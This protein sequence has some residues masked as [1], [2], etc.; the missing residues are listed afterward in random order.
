MPDAEHPSDAYDILCSTLNNER[1]RKRIIGALYGYLKSRIRAGKLSAPPDLRQLA[2]VLLGDVAVVALERAATFDTTKDPLAWLLGIALNTVRGYNRDEAR[3][4]KRKADP[5][6]YSETYAAELVPA[7]FDDDGWDED[8]LFG[9][10]SSNDDRI[11]LDA[12]LD[13]EQYLDQLEEED[14]DIIRR[15][16]LEKEPLIALAAEAGVPKN[17]MK[18]RLFRARYRLRDLRADAPEP[19]R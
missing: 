19:K 18:Q 4:A 2:V 1:Y 13:V 14:A 5:D 6:R 8:G 3:A 11:A 7:G 9:R 12:K 17:T 16:D 10:L 15:H